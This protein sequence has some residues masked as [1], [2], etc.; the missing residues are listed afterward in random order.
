MT[1]AAAQSVDAGRSGSTELPPAGSADGVTHRT[2]VSAY[3]IYTSGFT[4]QPKGVGV[5]HR[6]LAN[7][8]GVGAGPVRIRAGGRYALLQAQVTDLGNTV[9]FASAGTGG[10]AARPAGRRGARTRNVAAYLRGAPRSTTCKVVPVASGRA[11]RGGG[12]GAAAPAGVAGAR[13]RGAPSPALVGD[14]WRP[15]GTARMF[16]HYG[17]TETTIGWPPPS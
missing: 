9:V 7:Y 17:P 4:G 2:G 5:T 1:P 6:G 14:R 10:R 3:V 11:D 15:P 12:P 13:R 16:N 8:I